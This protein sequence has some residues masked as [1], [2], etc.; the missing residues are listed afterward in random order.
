MNDVLRLSRGPSCLT[1]SLSH[2]NDYC[3]SGIE[4]RPESG[5]AEL[6]SQCPAARVLPQASDLRAQAQ[7]H[8]TAKEE[9]NA[10]SF[11][12]YGR[13]FTRLS[14]LNVSESY[15]L[16]FLTFSK[17]TGSKREHIG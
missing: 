9:P 12:I 10:I 8:C 13:F 1:I 4:E 3:S 17:S 6:C 2:Q 7:S 5:E 14:F 16:L 15:S 11:G